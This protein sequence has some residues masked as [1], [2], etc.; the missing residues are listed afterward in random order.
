V[1]ESAGNLCQLHRTMSRRM[2]DKIAM[3][4]PSFGRFRDISYRDVRRQADRAAAGLITLGIAPGDRVGI[5]S[6]NR[7]EWPIADLGVLSA[8][9]ADVTMHAPLSADQ[10]EYQLGHSE[11]RGVLV[12]NQGQADKVISRLDHLPDL[13]FLV[14]FEPVTLPESRLVQ[15]SWQGLCHRGARASLDDQIASREQALGSSSLATLI[16]TSGTTGNPKGVM[17]THGNL[18]SNVESMI[19]IAFLEPDDILLSWLPYSHVYA[20]LTDNYLATG[21]G[22]T[23][24]LA[25]GIDTLISDLDRIKP[26]WLT[27]VPRFYEKIWTSLEALDPDTRADRLKTIFGPRIRQLNSG[28]AP[29]P[30]HVCDGFDQAGLPILEGYGLTE[31]S[32]VIAFNHAEAY[33]F[34][35]V[36]LPIPGVE[37]RIA[38][39]GEILTRG[40]HVMAGYWKNPEATEAVLVDGWFHTG[41]VGTI[42]EDGFL[43]ITDRKKDL[44][45]T[46]AGKNVAPAVIERLLTTDPLFDQAVVYGD[47]RNFISAVVVPNLP[48]LETLA[49]SNDTVMETADGLITSVKLLAIIDEKVAELMKSVS[50]PERVKKCLVLDKPF[51]LENDELTATLKVRRRHIIAK[52]EDRLEAF[53]AE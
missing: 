4:F 28:G 5:L 53:Y 7:V 34:G 22:I 39:D 2:G 45:V 3:R 35:S 52:Y 11:A 23:V 15:L 25:T 16:Y 40:P 32:P 48:V 13:E 47:G 30:Q 24:A 31:T 50:Q 14:S 44:F 8:G 43:S 29:L 41:D 21:A 9:A 18:L 46:S 1:I 19:P 10:V 17:L 27:A 42:D 33:R 51:Q 12:S 38:Q 37:V 26:T 36:G 6:E 20:R 49:A